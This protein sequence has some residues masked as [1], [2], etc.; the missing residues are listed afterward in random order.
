MTAIVHQDLLKS[1]QEILSF[2]KRVKKDLSS[3][4]TAEQLG[5]ILDET[6]YTIDRL[7]VLIQ[8]AYTIRS[9]D[10]KLGRR[11]K[12]IDIKTMCE[13]AANLIAAKNHIEDAQSYGKKL[14]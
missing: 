14:K 2:I 1:F 3:A 7:C 8:C 9:A 13:T 5:I 11:M 10:K 12:Y 6:T 4:T